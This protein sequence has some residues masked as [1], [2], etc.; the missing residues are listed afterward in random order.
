[1]SKR[2]LWG[3]VGGFVVVLALILMSPLGSFLRTAIVKPDIN[4]NYRPLV[5]HQQSQV[6]CYD[7]GSL[8]CENRKPP[9]TKEF[10]IGYLMANA[11]IPVTGIE[12]AMLYSC[13]NYSTGHYIV[14]LIQAQCGIGTAYPTKLALGY[15]FSEPSIE[16]PVMLFRCLDTAGTDMLV[17]D[18]PQ[19]C[20][21][22]GYQERQFLG[23][24]GSAGY[25]WQRRL[26]DFCTTVSNACVAGRAS[27]SLCQER[28]A[29]CG[30]P[31]PSPTPAPSSSPTR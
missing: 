22:V 28:Q 6:H 19:E 14:T 25:L 23:Y 16:T 30:F 13:A 9:F 15:V 20:D 18:D 27:A 12:R 31:L 21:L 8:F 10:T 2:M 7:N 17:T 1:M 11:S 5:R 29:F 4:R 26:E 3:A 24:V